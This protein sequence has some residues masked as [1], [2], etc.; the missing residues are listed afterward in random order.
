MTFYQQT[1]YPVRILDIPCFEK[2]EH[3]QKAIEKFRLCW[4]KINKIKDNLH[5][6]LYFLNFNEN[7]TFQ[8]L[9]AP[10]L[11]EIIKHK[12]C[13]IIYVVT[14]CHKNI[15]QNK[16]AKK[17]RQIY[18]GIQGISKEK[19]K[20]VFDET[21]EGGMLFPSSNNV[22]FVNFHKNY[23]DGSDPFWKKNLFKAIHD[24][25][26]QSEDYKKSLEKLDENIIKENADKLRARGKE[27]LLANKVWGGIVG[28]I[29]ELI[30]YCKSLLLKK[31][32]QKN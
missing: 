30:G 10:I 16:K 26:I 6:I 3:V 4:E 24:S 31:M 2:E 25:F 11:E 9:E 15:S 20:A 22:V 21:F 28:I 18:E 27:L 1:N 32:Q 7:R 29:M 13:K 17:I 14:H 23:M 19:F 5:I 8:E 12:T